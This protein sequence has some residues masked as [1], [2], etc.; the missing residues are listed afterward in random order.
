MYTAKKDDFTM[1]QLLKALDEHP[2]GCAC[3]M[4]RLL[5]WKIEHQSIDIQGLSREFAKYKEQ[6][7]QLKPKYHENKS[8]PH[9]VKIEPI[10]DVAKADKF[11]K[12]W[13][14]VTS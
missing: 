1:Q 4:C 9:E 6:S 14:Y 13:T 11:Q 2:G 10:L 3:N 12:D 7:Q 5:Q 8:S